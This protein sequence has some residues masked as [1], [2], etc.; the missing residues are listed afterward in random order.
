MIITIPQILGVVVGI[1]CAHYSY[2]QYRKK[3]FSIVDL[4]FWFV[5]WGGLVGLS[6]VSEFI[7]L[8]QVIYIYSIFDIVIVLSI[9]LLFCI[10][11]VLYMKSKLY[12]Q[13][14]REVVRKTALID[15]KKSRRDGSD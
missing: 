8:T 1:F 2:I 7:S 3:V 4:S 5:V 10:V 12:Q 6:A 13:K 15:A 11:F 9:V 14:I